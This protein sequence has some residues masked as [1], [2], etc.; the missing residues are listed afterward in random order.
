MSR[1]LD[2]ISQMVTDTFKLLEVSGNQMEMVFD[3]DGAHFDFFKKCLVLRLNTQVV[4]IPQGWGPLA[5]TI[6]EEGAQ[7]D[8]CLSR[9]WDPESLIPIFENCLGYELERVE[10][11]SNESSLSLI[12]VA[13]EDSL[14]AA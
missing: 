4:E 10:I 12:L 13:S 2:Y 11:K 9:N 3:S 8:I 6:V 1:K 5:G 7:L 14:Q